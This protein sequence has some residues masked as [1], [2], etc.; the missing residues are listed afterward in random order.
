MVTGHH[1]LSIQYEFFTSKSYKSQTMFLN[2]NESESSDD[3]ETN[4]VN[5]EITIATLKAFNFVDQM[6]G[7]IS[8]FE[9][10]L[11][12]A[13]EVYCKSHRNFEERWPR[14]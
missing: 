10:L 3:T 5:I 14:N 9:D 6:K 8:D 13:K 11:Q 2:I 1:W 7:S 12:F 4:P